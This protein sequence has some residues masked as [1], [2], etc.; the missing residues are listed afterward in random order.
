MR[1]SQL[2]PVTQR[3]QSRVHRL[4]RSKPVVALLALTWCGSALAQDTLPELIG[5]PFMTDA[6]AALN[7]DLGHYPSAAFD[8]SNYLVVFEDAG[9]IQGSRI[10]AD[11]NPIDIEWLH[12]QPRDNDADLHYY[13]PSVAFG[14]GRYLAAWSGSQSA[15]RLIDPDGTLHPIF[16]LG[17]NGLYP[18]ISWNGEVFVVVWMEVSDAGRDTMLAFVDID[19]NITF[20]TQ[21]SDSGDTSWPSVSSGDSM[22]IVAWENAPDTSTGEIYAARVDHDGT[23]L[24]PGGVR[25]AFSDSDR[26]VHTAS[27]GDSFLVAW[28]DY[29][30]GGPTGVVATVI[31]EDGSLT[32]SVRLNDPSLEGRDFN[33]AFDGEQYA[34]T[35]LDT[36]EYP[37]TLWGSNVSTTGNAQAPV[38]IPSYNPRSNDPPHLL[39]ANDR[40]LLSYVGEGIIGGFLDGK[41]TSEAQDIPLSFIE[42]YQETIQSTFDGTHYVLSWTERRGIEPQETARATQVSQGGQV[43]DAETIQLGDPGEEYSASVALASAGNGSS[44]SVWGNRVTETIFAQMRKADG[45]LGPTHTVVTGTGSWVNLASN[46]SGYLAAY[47]ARNAEDLSEMRGQFLD[48]EGAPVGDSFVM[49]QTGVFVGGSLTTVG[50]GYLWFWDDNESTYLQPIPSSGELPEPILLDAGRTGVRTATN[51]TES[52]LFYSKLGADGE[53]REPMV[54]FVSPD[55]WHGTDMPLGEEFGYVHAVWDGSQFVIATQDDAN[56]TYLQTLSLDGELSDRR[57]VLTEDAYV[58]G[59]ASNGEGQ[60]LLSYSRAVNELQRSRRIFNRLIGDP[61]EVD[62]SD[63]VAPVPPRAGDPSTADDETSASDD[64][65]DDDTADDDTADDGPAD[66]GPAQDDDSDAEDADD[67][68]T[69]AADDETNA[70]DDAANEASDEGTAQDADDSAEQATSPAA[71]GSDGPTNP[72]DG[73]V[74]VNSTDPTSEGFDMD[75]ESSNNSSGGCSVSRGQPPAVAWSLVALAALALARRR[76]G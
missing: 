26:Y 55:D 20:Q 66:D 73:S 11:G 70:A 16:P 27:S 10:D 33:A 47:L 42:A 34:V 61:L 56:M 59:L 1:N 12:L 71:A 72:D 48:L 38:T 57:Q 36:T 22:S 69:N 35:W 15:A 50:D 45:S 41:L 4:L 21:V 75:G 67:D 24:D 5:E 37:Y 28:N 2:Q 46:G 74:Q 14:G 31:S 40:Y 60:L 32:D 58:Y 49:R 13:Y 53:T 19:G 9:A 39:W 25:V 64:T 3:P 51:G 65:A 8:G 18:S 6:P 52:I 44:V 23:V 62:L 30:S 63:R 54:R 76:R 17:S 29:G 68:E 7:Y 43:L